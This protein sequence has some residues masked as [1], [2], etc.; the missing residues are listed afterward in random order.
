MRNLFDIPDDYACSETS[1]VIH[2]SAT[3]AGRFCWDS[4]GTLWRIFQSASV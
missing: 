1:K 3:L 4:A 2:W